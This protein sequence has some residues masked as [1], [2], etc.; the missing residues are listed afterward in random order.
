[1]AAGGVVRRWRLEMAGRARSGRCGYVGYGGA[2]EAAGSGRAAAAG[3]GVQRRRGSGC[4]WVWRWRRWFIC[5]VIF[6][7][8]V[9][10]K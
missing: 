6:L 2:A 1:V 7:N 4:V 3:L 5:V 8:K 10:A 9:S